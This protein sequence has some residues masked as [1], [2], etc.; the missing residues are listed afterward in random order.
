MSNLAFKKA[1][2]ILKKM[3]YGQRH[4]AKE[5]G[6]SQSVISKWLVRRQIPAE[7]V[8]R[9]EAITMGDVTR[10]ELRP[11]LY[12]PVIKPKDSTNE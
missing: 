1:V 11:D 2:T 4:L 9:I 10:Y 5:L 8:L 3:G 7:Y 6:V 12:P